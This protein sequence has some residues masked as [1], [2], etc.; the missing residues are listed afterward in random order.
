LRFKEQDHFKGSSHLTAKTAEGPSLLKFDGGAGQNFQLTRTAACD[1]S[2]SHKVVCP[3]IV[4]TS[5]PRD[6]AYE[7]C[8]T[9]AVTQHLTIQTTKPHRRNDESCGAT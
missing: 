6:N 9:E 8:H 5:E 2:R 3:E 4:A 7:G 1:P